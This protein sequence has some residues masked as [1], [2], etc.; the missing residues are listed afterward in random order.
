MTTITEAK[1]NLSKLICA[2]EA[3][4]DIYI[5]RHGQPVAALISEAR[6][7][8]FFSSGKGVFQAINAWR[9]RSGGVE[10]SDTEVDSWRDKIPTREFSSEIS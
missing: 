3:D 1:N 7:Q 5:S 9:E 8:Q 4:C 10:L 2:A 6:Y